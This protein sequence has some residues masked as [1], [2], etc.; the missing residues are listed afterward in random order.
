M[1]S[2]TLSF[3]DLIDESYLD[4]PSDPRKSPPKGDVRRSFGPTIVLSPPQSDD[5]RP[6]SPS[7]QR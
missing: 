1:P 2:K 3:D 7:E 6:P 4:V 5:S